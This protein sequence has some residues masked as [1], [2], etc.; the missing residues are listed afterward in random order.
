MVIEYRPGFV[1]VNGN[2]IQQSRSKKPT[3]EFV[4]EPA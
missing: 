2:S 1:T 4:G 3:V